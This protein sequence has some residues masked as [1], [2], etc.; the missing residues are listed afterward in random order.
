MAM[1]AYFSETGVCKKKPGGKDEASAPK[2]NFPFFF[3]TL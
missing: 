1:D 3:L 2:V